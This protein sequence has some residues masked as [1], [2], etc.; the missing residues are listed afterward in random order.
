[1]TSSAR[2]AWPPRWWAGGIAWGLWSLAMLG[3]V[4]TAW[5]DRLLR[6]AGHPELAQL[7]GG[8]VAVVLSAVSAATAGAVLASR[9]TR[10]PVGWLLLAFGL[11][12]QAL[13]S[14]AEGY[15]RY[16]LL[17]RPGTLP[18][19]EQLATLASATFVPGLS[20]VAFILLLTPTGSLPSPRWRWFARVAAALPV[21]FLAAWLLAVPQLDPESPLASVRNPFA[22]PGL[23]GAGMAV[24]GVASP[25]IGLTLAVSA[26]SLV[27]RFRRSRGTERQQLRWLAEAAALAPVVVLATAAA[28]ATSN[29]VLAGWT[30]GLY[31]ALLPLAI[32]AAIARYRLYDLDR[33]VSRTVAYGLLTLVLGGGYAVVVLGLGQLLPDSSSLVVAAA[34][35]AA[36]ALFQPA[37]RRVQRAVDRRFNR[38]RYDAARTVQA[39]ST[40]LRDQVD[41]DALHDELL[42]V[43]DQTMQPT[44]AS[45]WLRPQALSTT[46]VRPTVGRSPTG[47]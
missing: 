26:A 39:F 32:A 2:P 24:A 23:A 14:A 45:L 16:G 20:L 28:I 37:R 47:L 40:R 33:I 19:A 6:Q 21:L 36:A 38:R 44:R 3:L 43:V 9:R 12:P 31:L 15:A 18:G 42:A 11:I 34:T 7:R 1:V 29:L 25:A 41:L 35:L 10:H 8:G 5:F 22:I 46:A 27:L 17:A 13:S 4:A 30:I